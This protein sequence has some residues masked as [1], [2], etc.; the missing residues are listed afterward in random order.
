MF[1]FRCLQ[2]VNIKLFTGCKHQ[3]VACCYKLGLLLAVVQPADQALI[4][5]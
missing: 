5:S 3:A 1:G 4:T 2:V